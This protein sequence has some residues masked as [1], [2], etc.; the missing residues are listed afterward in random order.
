MQ[1]RIEPIFLLQLIV[2]TFFS[3][4]FHRFYTN[5]TVR[6]V[7]LIIISLLS[8]LHLINLFKHILSY[9]SNDFKKNL[10]LNGMDKRKID[11]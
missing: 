9:Y 2:P 5:L 1:P 6:T 4:H 10:E 7:S 3:P 8:D 11:R